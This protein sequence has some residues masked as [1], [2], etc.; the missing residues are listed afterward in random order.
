MFQKPP[1]VNMMRTYGME[2]ISQF[3]GLGGMRSWVIVII[4]VRL[5]L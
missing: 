1:K 2:T 3:G 5:G 4:Y